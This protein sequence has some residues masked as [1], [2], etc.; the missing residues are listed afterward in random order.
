ML[1]LF[2]S[3]RLCPIAQ[4]RW[5]ARINIDNL[6]IIYWLYVNG[7][8]GEWEE[9]NRGSNKKNREEKKVN[10]I[11]TTNKTCKL[12]FGYI[13][14]RKKRSKKCVRPYNREKTVL[15]FFNNMYTWVSN[16]KKK[17]KRKKYGKIEHL[18]VK[19]INF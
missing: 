11:R 18:S 15:Y 9:V 1:S 17:K 4:L 3:F 6:W 13:I 8:G 14:I 12:L 10:T 2:S 19:G 7:G 16:S 5:L